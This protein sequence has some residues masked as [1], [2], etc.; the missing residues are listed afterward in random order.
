MANRLFGHMPDGTPVQ[1]VI[2]PCTI[3][4]GAEA[5]EEGQFRIQRFDTGA[6]SQIHWGI[7]FQQR[8]FQ[9]TANRSSAQLPAGIRGNDRTAADRA[10]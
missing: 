1:A 3:G 2:S 6:F 7:S 8:F 9:C 5:G 4:G 10:G